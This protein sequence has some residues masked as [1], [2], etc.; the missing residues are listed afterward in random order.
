MSNLPANIQNMATALV[1]SSV[2]AGAAGGGE[3]YMQFTKF[4]EW[5][6]GTDKTEPEEGS[7]W[8]VNP[9][10]FMHGF[11]AWDQSNTSQG[12]TGEVMVNAG[13]PLPAEADLPEVAG[14]WSKAIAMT[15]RCTNGEDE[16][17][18]CLWKGNSLGARKAYAALLQPV[19]ERIGQGKEDFVPLVELGADSYTHKTYGK[20]F[21]PELTI[22]GWTTM[23][24]TATEE[25][26]E[27]EAAEVE[28][29]EKPARRRRRK[30]A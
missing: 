25:V 14:K 27:T 28:P 24:G 12:P 9:M 23:D 13:S 4:G 10:Q 16:G 20:I 8:A 21:A 17:I 26:E 18:Q 1:Q 11:I 3:L 30:A 2:S 22:V 6:F 15:L 29:E 7:V 5:V 19:A